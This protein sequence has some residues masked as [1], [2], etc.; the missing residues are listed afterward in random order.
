[1]LIV[2]RLDTTALFTMARISSTLGVV[3]MAMYYPQRLTI[4]LFVNLLWDILFG[5]S[6][7][8]ATSRL[9]I[10]NHPIKSNARHVSA[11]ISRQ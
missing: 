7:L 8:G 6:F 11:T 5:V 4:S 9:D 3:T 1:M 10:F 2:Y